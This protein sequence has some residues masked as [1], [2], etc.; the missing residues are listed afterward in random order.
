MVSSSQVRSGS[1]TGAPPPRA[2]SQR[3]ARGGPGVGAGEY[4]GA[5]ATAASSRRITAWKTNG[6]IVL[7]VSVDMPD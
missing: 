2:G 3:R 1:G 7:W 4:E 6:I 5:C